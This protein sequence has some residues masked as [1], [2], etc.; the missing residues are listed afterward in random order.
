MLKEAKIKMKQKFKFNSWKF[1]F[2]DIQA[3]SDNRKIGLH[4]GKYLHMISKGYQQFGIHEGELQQFSKDLKRLIL[5]IG[6][7]KD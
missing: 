1:R 7:T 3:L 4:I 2:A 6:I 5:K